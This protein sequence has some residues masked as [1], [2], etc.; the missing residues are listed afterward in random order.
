MTEPLVWAK[1]LIYKFNI[2]VPR[3]MVE[4]KVLEEHLASEIVK[5]QTEAIEAATVRVVDSRRI[6]R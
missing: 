4:K 2:P 1:I 3:S 5:I 6:E